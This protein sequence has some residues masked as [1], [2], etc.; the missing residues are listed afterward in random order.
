LPP[1]RYPTGKFNLIYGV[2]V[3]THLDEDYQRQWL[4]ELKRITARG[5]L[6]LLTTH[7]DTFFDQLPS[8]LAAA[9]EPGFLF[10]KSA[11]WKGIFPEW[12]QNTLQTRKYVEE[13][14]SKHFKILNYIPKGL[15]DYQ[16]MVVLQNAR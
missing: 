7:G 14:Y 10:L 3:M 8:E 11:F 6:V 9:R 13:N 4:L 1:L 12:Y 5:G 2:S 16:D 15:C